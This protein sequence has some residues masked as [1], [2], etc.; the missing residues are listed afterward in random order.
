MIRRIGLIGAGAFLLW[1]AACSDDPLGL[2]RDLQIELLGDIAGDSISG[3]PGDTLTLS[4]RAIDRDGAPIAGAEVTTAVFGEGAEVLPG[5]GVTALDGSFS[6]GWQLGTLASE[7]QRL[8]VELRFAGRRNRLVLAGSVVPRDIVSVVGPDSVATRLHSPASLIVVAIDPYGNVFQPESIGYRST[9]TT[10]FVIDSTGSIQGRSRGIAQAIATSGSEADTTMIHIFQVVDSIAAADRLPLHSIGQVATLGFVILSDSGKEIRDS[11]PQ[12]FLADSTIAR[13]SG[14]VTDSS[15]AIEGLANGVAMLTIALG[16]VERQVEIQ[17]RQKS[18]SLTLSPAAPLSFGAL[19]DSIQLTAVAYDS[20]GV[21]LAAPAFTF[22]TADSSVARVGTGGVVTS[23]GNG[24]TTVTAVE[25]TGASGSLPVAVAQVPDSLEVFW[26]DAH[27]IRMT[28]S[29]GG[30]LLVCIARDRNGFVIPGAEQVT[31]MT[32]LTAGDRCDNLQALRSGFDTLLVQA[33]SHQKQVEGPIAIRPSLSAPLGAPLAVDSVPAAVASWAPTLIRNTSGALDVYFTGYREDS[34]VAV[35]FS[36]DLHRLTSTDDGVSFRYDGVALARDPVPCSPEGNGIENVA[37]VPRADG[38]GWRMFYAAGGFTCYG[39]QVF[40]ATSPD[41]RTW[42]RENG[43]RISNG[44]PLPPSPPPPHI[45]WPAGEGIVVDQLPS[46]EWRMIAGTYENIPVPEDKFQIT[47]WRSPDQLH[48]T[49]RGVV[50]R[51][52]E[53]GPSAQRSIYSPTIREFVPGVFRMVFTG[54]NLNVP[55]GRSRLYTALSLDG[56]SWQFEGLLME[57]AGT[58][59][60][61]STLV[62]DLLVFIRQEI[63]QLRYLASARLTMP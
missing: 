19:G 41:Q 26:P 48:W 21:E 43:A 47:E 44:T 14:P 50:L 25:I 46:G 11:I 61:Y 60:F 40:S 9:D 49:Y 39:W 52:D 8:E 17:V 29:A 31:S 4:F 12:V 15:V 59:I 30:L 54:D 33:G 16:A 58:D 24:S 56:S 38:P 35:G 36:G 28:D 62:G 2:D 53:V 34:T 37:V 1:V 55:G 51:T 22:V 45:P 7:R 20:V 63:G 23:A 32:G 42:T 10:V 27:P 3:G 57:G 6:I 18:F 13:L 5:P